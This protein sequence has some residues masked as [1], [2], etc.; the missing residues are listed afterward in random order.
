MK[1]ACSVYFF[2]ACVILKSLAPCREKRR[3]EVKSG[4]TAIN[5]PL[6]QSFRRCML[7]SY[8]VK[9]RKGW[10]TLTSDRNIKVQNWMKPCDFPLTNEVDFYNRALETESRPVLPLF[11]MIFFL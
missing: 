3:Y 9:L 5:L 4:Y 6:I 10:K 7:C 8:H 2:D 1:S 11:V